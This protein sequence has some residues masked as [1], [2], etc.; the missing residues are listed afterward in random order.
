MQEIVL[1]AVLPC[2]GAL[3]MFFITPIIFKSHFSSSFYIGN[4]ILYLW[5]NNDYTRKN[6]SPK[7][8]A[9]VA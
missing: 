4:Q 9:A 1:Y 7:N 8:K 5:C 6:L 3:H 2:T